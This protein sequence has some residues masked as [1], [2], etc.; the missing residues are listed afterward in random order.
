MGPAGFR[1]VLFCGRGNFR[2]GIPLGRAW[3]SLSRTQKFIREIEKKG[4]LFLGECG[5]LYKLT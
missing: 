3:N 2:Q 4:L 1:R 5:N